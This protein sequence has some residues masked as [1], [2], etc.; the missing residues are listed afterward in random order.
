MRTPRPALALL[1]TLGVSGLGLLSGC[2]KDSA[3]EDTLTVNGDVAIAYVKRA[4]TTSRD[5]C[6]G[7]ETA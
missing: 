5:G 4:T 6:S 1:L 7:T 3:S 2:G